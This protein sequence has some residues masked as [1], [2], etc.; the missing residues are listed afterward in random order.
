MSD[1]D[2]RETP[3]SA[4]NRARYADLLGIYRELFPAL[5]GTFAKLAGLAGG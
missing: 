2:L 4:E 1:R 3:P 5:R